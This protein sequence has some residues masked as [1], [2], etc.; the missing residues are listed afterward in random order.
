MMTTSQSKSTRQNIKILELNINGLLARKK[1]LEQFL[2]S[3]RIDVA[4]IAE[5][6]LTTRMLAKI[7]NYNLFTSNHPSGGSHGGAALYIRNDIP[8]FEEQ[9]YSTPH[10]Q[11]ACATIQLHCGTFVKIAAVYSPPAHKITTEDYLHFFDHP[12]DR[13]IAGGDYNSK[14]MY[15]GSRITTTKGKALYL[16]AEQVHAQCWSNGLPTYWPTDVSKIPE[17]LDFFMV[18]GI[19]ANYIDLQNVNNDLSSDHSPIVLNISDVLLKKKPTTG[20]TNKLTNWDQFRD[21]FS[22]FALGVRLKTNEELDA[23]VRKFDS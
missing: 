3:E 4:M 22:H 19:S 8:Q 6:H 10:L 7:R 11:A 1:E 21:E 5:S 16:A 17:C 12:G 2:H 18:R 14:N 9:P 13:W 20:L 15:W 23:A